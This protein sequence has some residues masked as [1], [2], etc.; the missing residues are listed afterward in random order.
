MPNRDGTRKESGVTPQN[1]GTGP[2]CRACRRSEHEYYPECLV[3]SERDCQFAVFFHYNRFCTHP[4]HDLIATS[5]K[6]QD[7]RPSDETLG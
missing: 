6:A 1:L 4:N 5:T 7:T 3:P 2:D